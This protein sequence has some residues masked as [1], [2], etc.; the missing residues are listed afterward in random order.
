ML[1][2]MPYLPPRDEE[3]AIRY[4]ACD[5][6][7]LVP[8]EDAQTSIGLDQAWSNRNKRAEIVGFD[9][10]QDGGPLP[11]SPP[12]FD[13]I[14][15]L[16][17]RPV[18]QIPDLFLFGVGG[19]RDIDDDQTVLAYQLRRAHER[20]FGATSIDEDEA[21]LPQQ[22]G[23]RRYLS[24]TNIS[25]IIRNT[26]GNFQLSISSRFSRRDG[27]PVELWNDWFIAYMMDKVL[28][29]NLLRLDFSA[30]PESSWKHLLMLMFA[31]M[32]KR[33]MGKGVFRQYVWHR[34]NDSNPRGHIDIARHV[35]YNTP[36]IGK[37]AY[38]TREFDVDNPVT[39]LIRH[40]IEYLE[41]HD[42]FSRSAL[43]QDTKVHDCINL[44]RA[45]TN[46]YCKESRARVLDENI[47][48]PVNHSYYYEYRD[49]QR[50]CIGILAGRGARYSS[51]QGDQIQGVL[52]DC[53]WLWE[54]YLATVLRRGCPDTKHPHNKEGSEKN[55]LF[56]RDA[57]ASKERPSYV[58]LIYPDFYVAGDGEKPMVM[59]AKYR[60]PHRIV[61]D[62]YQQVL[63]Y[64]LRFG[65]D[66]GLYLHP[67]ASKNERELICKDTLDVLD[68]WDY[69]QAQSQEKSVAKLGLNVSAANAI[70]Y[71]EYCKNMQEREKAFL[72][73]IFGR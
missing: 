68:G 73:A 66:R 52:F 40:T 60:P 8:P 46:N 14:Q 29:F 2:W 72:K 53:A 43:R 3:N 34:H 33:A 42:D 4:L 5:N 11:L 24:T 47:R 58:G 23:K 31:S 71:A 65:S 10:S 13:F 15:Q 49:L 19:I 55:W 28:H 32:L 12:Q 69:R 18:L 30:Q 1:S 57:G 48:K 44:I 16:L 21:A 70:D 45:C 20:D 25:G 41:Q 51:T 50:L 59:D 64:M 36:F 39:Q 35:R 56:R 63:A 7:P 61:R 37:V 17:E 38:E 54:E 22:R 9:P 27:M 62:D 26:S 67:F 6:S